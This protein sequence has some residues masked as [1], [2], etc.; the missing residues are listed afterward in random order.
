[1]E[2][3]AYIADDLWP[4]CR[5]ID[6]LVEDPENAN[7]HPQDNLATIAGS[8]RLFKQTRNVVG[9]TRELDGK[10]VIFAGNG[11]LDRAKAM[12]WKW[13]AVVVRDDLTED[14]ARAFALA[15]NRSSALAIFDEKVLAAQLREL[16][17]DL[18]IDIGFDEKEFAR[19]QKVLE[20]DLANNSAGA[21]EEKDPD[22]LPGRPVNPITQNGDI[23]C[24]GFH[25]VICGDSTDPATV[26]RL[27]GDA[28]PELM[29][30]DPPYGVNYD[31]EWRHDAALNNS[32]RT[33]TVAND[34]RADWR[35]AW[36]LFPGD[37]AYVWHAGLF[38]GIVGDSLAACGF[39]LRSQIM[40]FKPRFA[41]G[42][43]AYHWQHEPC[44]YAVRKGKSAEWAA[45]RSE[46][47]VWPIDLPA[48]WEGKTTHGTQKPVECMEKPM[49]NHVAAAVYDPFLGSGTT[50]I[51]AERQG[52]VCY[53]AELL[54]AYA[55]V[56][57]RRWCRYTGL[58][59]TRESD[60]AS[61]RTLE[62]ETDFRTGNDG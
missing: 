23:W 27:L 5:P 21:G 13:L 43:G 52:T 59:A 2:R 18:R 38:A 42:R 56:I 11:V 16:G 60:G 40:W 32:E 17:T 41:I 9:R 12:G 61:F 37:V 26:A 39:Q 34:D 7:L 6:Q 25:R 14:E 24:L 58:D 36:A 33:G 28:K 8:L 15:D 31:P 47:T 55:D 57:V 45:G 1:M 44:W 50:L 46:T 35:E 10:I 62:A 22:A 30:T 3:P 53:G 4:I 48:R 19:L 54:P 49:R 29:V 51:A 20:Q